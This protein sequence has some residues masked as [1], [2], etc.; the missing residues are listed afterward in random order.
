MPLH[1]LQLGPYPPPEGGI[2]RNIIGIRN[3]LQRRGHPCSIIA[4]S[5]SSSET[6]EPN[7]YHPRT[8]ASLLSRLVLSD[9]DILHLHIGGDLTRRVVAL[10]LVCTLVSRKC[11]L[12][13]H[14]GGYPLT[15][16]GQN[17]SSSSLRG[18]IFRR[19]SQIIAINDQMRDLFRSYG[20]ADERLAVVPPYSLAPPDESTVIPSEFMAFFDEHSP[21]F[22]AVGGLE[23]DYQP[24]F[25]V[26]AM[27]SIL[28]DFPNAGL[29]I[30][31]GGSLRTETEQAILEGGHEGRIHLIGSIDHELSLHLM[32]R[33][34]VMIRSSLFDGDAISIREAM[35]LGTPVV[36]TDTGNRP[37][38]VYLFNIGDLSGLVE[39][40][41]TAV[42]TGKKDTKLAPADVSNLAAVVDIYEE[43]SRSA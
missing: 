3:E 15:E 18:R 9:F 16:E 29:M 14:S 4:T 38:G 7:V 6:M 10:A 34:D 33:A 37:D 28:E 40:L 35:F 13:L 24:L 27:D 25:L 30:V 32:R 5:R 21:V 20:V 41:N 17:A 12:T 19:F 39:H 22:V 1:V 43:L 23:D 11:V 26:S 31:G 8:A 42:A 2:T 36:A